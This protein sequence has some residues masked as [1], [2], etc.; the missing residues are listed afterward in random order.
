M[1]TQNQHLLQQLAERDDYNI[2]DSSQSED[3]MKVHITEALS[4][5]QEDRHLALILETVKRELGDADKELKWLR[6]AASSSGEGIP[7]AP[8][9][10]G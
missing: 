8:E 10:A 7:T 1:Q 3:Q 9:K 5:T 2:K 4:Y 6:S